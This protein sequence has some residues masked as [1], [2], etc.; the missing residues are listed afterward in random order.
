MLQA[1]LRIV[2]PLVLIIA[3]FIYNVYVGLLT[4]IL[5]IVYL[6]YN[7]RADL[8]AMK[9][10]K[11]WSE[12]KIDEARLYA[13]KAFETKPLDPS[14]AIRY[15][16]SL[17]RFND[18]EQAEA[19]LT[20]VSEKKLSR[21]SIM[22]LRLNKAIL[23]W[24]QGREE[25]S[26]D[27]ALKL[28]EE[29]TNSILYGTLGYLLI[30]K[31]DLGKA[32]SYNLEAYE[33]NDTNTAILD[34]IGLTYYKLEQFDKA[35][36]I[37][38]KLIPL[39]PSFREAHFNYGLILERNNQMELALEQYKIALTKKGSLVSHVPLETIEDKIKLLAV[40]DPSEI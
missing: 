23:F 8:Y 13:K 32:L 37:Y 20:N 22:S 5:F 16:Y 14:L 19:I 10:N 40:L 39:N 9:S 31:G 26:L 18:F 1:I 35:L 4:I 12:G 3:A 28:Q 17:I 29:Y 2:I 27:I 7:A 30:L 33:Y 11:K 36:E 25:E 34:N 15:G 21:E 38:E 24:K 6:I